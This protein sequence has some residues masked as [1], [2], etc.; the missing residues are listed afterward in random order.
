MLGTFKAVQAIIKQKLEV[1]RPKQDTVDLAP[2]VGNNVFYIVGYGQNGEGEFLYNAYPAVV[3]AVYQEDAHHSVDLFVMGYTPENGLTERFIIGSDQLG[4]PVGVGWMHAKDALAFGKPLRVSYFERMVA[5][6]KHRTVIH[7][8]RVGQSVTYHSPTLDWKPIP[9]IIQA[10]NEDG[11]VDLLVFIPE[12]SGGT[13][14]VY[15]IRFGASIPPYNK[16]EPRWWWVHQP[17]NSYTPFLEDGRLDKNP[18]VE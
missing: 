7:T 14:E 18:G 4:L 1:L 16:T 8:P 5:H 15:K 3:S 9:A 13:S 12:K 2:E 17:S 6:T 10:T 11:T